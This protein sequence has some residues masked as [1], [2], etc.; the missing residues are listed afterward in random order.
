MPVATWS[1][2]S[3]YN[4][5][6]KPR[7]R[8]NTAHISHNVRVLEAEGEGRVELSNW[9]TSREGGSADPTCTDHPTR[10]RTAFPQ[11]IC[12]RPCVYLRYT[13]EKNRF[14]AYNIE[15]FVYSGGS[16]TSNRAR[17]YRM[18]ESGVVEHH[19]PHEEDPQW[20]YRGSEGRVI[21][22]H[23]HTQTGCGGP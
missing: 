21:R 8:P 6:S 3:K 22:K 20:D 19:I 15:S 13:T 18:W 4:R 23:L 1:S 17:V 12:T 2:T 16:G 7:P 10:T 9:H 11:S 14:N 5:M